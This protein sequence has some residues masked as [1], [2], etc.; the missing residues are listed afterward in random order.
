[1]LLDRAWISGFV[2]FSMGFFFQ[3]SSAL[4]CMPS[5]RPCAMHKMQGHPKPRSAGARCEYICGPSV[6]SYRT[7]SR[8][9][10]ARTQSRNLKTNSPTKL[11]PAHGTHP[12]IC[13]RCGDHRISRADTTPEST[14]KHVQTPPPFP[15]PARNRSCNIM[16]RP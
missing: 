7:A 4:A 3:R 10:H 14:P 11:P 9:V 16:Y 15:V 6:G 2:E 5:A 13:S 8:R 1:M 12:E